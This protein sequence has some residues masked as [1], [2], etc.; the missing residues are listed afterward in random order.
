MILS[1]TLQ[2]RLVVEHP[3]SAKEACDLITEIFNDNK[4]S[5][6]IALKAEL[7]SL[8]LGDLS[9]DAYFQKIKSIATILRSLIS[10]VT[11]DDVVTFSLEG[12]SEKYENVC[13]I[14]THRE[15][16][17]DLKTARS[18]LTT[19]EMSQHT[20][21]QR[22]GYPGSDVLRRLVSRN[23]ISCNKE[24]LPV[25]WHVCQLGKHVRLPFV[26]SSTSVSSCVDIVHSDVWS[27]P[28]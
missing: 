8:K 3:Q 2:A 27:S 26:S 7:R 19:E 17:P 4:R 15:P 13:G 9:I 25:L 21:H 12:L 14:I 6:T 16:F 28:I 11:N 23:F 24:K 5:R 10:P 20:W 1:D 18:M 22:L